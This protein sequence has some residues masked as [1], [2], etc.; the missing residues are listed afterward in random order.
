MAIL[1]YFLCTTS[2]QSSDFEPTVYSLPLI[3]ILLSYDNYDKT[4][5]LSSD[6]EDLQ[7]IPP[8]KCIKT[9]SL[10]A[11]TEEDIALIAKQHNMVSVFMIFTPTAGEGEG[12]NQVTVPNVFSESQTESARHA[13][14]MIAIAN[15]GGGGD[16]DDDPPPAY[17]DLDFN[18]EERAIRE[19]EKKTKKLAKK[20]WKPVARYQ[21]TRSII[22]FANKNPAFSARSYKQVRELLKYEFFTIELLSRTGISFSIALSAFDDPLFASGRAL[23]TVLMSVVSSAFPWFCVD[24]S[25]IESSMTFFGAAMYTGVDNFFAHQTNSTY[26]IEWTSPELTQFGLKAF[27]VGWLHLRITKD[28]TGNII[29]VLSFLSRGH[30]LPILAIDTVAKPVISYLSIAAFFSIYPVICI[31]CG[32]NP[33]T[34]SSYPWP[35]YC[36]KI[37][38][39]PWLINCETNSTN[40]TVIE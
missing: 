23:T 27:F 32:P 16:P 22:R 5:S 38:W 3:G 2:V 24:N 39:I 35:D 11:W 40:Q 17:S 9:P 15:G 13:T 33:Y 8:E 25:L 36:P 31:S 4:F 29:S 10:N 19:L 21:L 30:L 28:I 14:P 12:E 18:D 7:L 26:A 20:G 6:Q 1:S 34:Q 37:K